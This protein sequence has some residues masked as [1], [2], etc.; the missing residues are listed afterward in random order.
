MATAI[1][2]GH[3]KEELRQE[4]SCAITKFERISRIITVLFYT[5]GLEEIVTSTSAILLHSLEA[6]VP[7]VKYPSLVLEGIAI[8]FASILVFVPLDNA[9]KS[10]ALARSSCAKFLNRASNMPP[11]VYDQLAS[12]ETLCFRHPMSD[13]PR[14]AASV[15]PIARPNPARAQRA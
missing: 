3:A 14:M 11:E 7:S 1:S 5:V 4:L 6:S 13:C 12:A 2:V 10:C 15:N 8:T 9:R